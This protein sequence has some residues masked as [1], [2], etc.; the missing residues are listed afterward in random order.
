MIVFVLQMRSMSSWT[1]VR[2]RV[3]PEVHLQEIQNTIVGSTFYKWAKQFES[4]CS[5]EDVDQLL[6]VDELIAPSVSVSGGR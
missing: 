3:M 6:F 5:M 2:S 4:T 1:S